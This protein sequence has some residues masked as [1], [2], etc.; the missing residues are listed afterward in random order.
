MLKNDIIKY[1]DDFKSLNNKINSFKNIIKE[2]EKELID[3]NDIKENNKELYRNLDEKYI[4]INKLNENNNNLINVMNDNEVELIN[5]S[6][7]KDDND[8]L[9]VDILN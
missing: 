3:Y 1:N 4:Q 9:N 5:Y 7:I 6:K 8:L 2:K